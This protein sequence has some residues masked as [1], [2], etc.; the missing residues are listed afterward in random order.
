MD[1]RVGPFITFG[2]DCDRP[3]AYAE[4][5]FTVLNKGTGACDSKNPTPRRS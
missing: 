4:E 1:I 5:L 2:V 3:N